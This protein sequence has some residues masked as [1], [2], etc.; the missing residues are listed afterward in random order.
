MK[1]NYPRI[2]K[3]KAPL[4][5]L[6]AVLLLAACGGGGSSGGSSPAGDGGLAGGGGVNQPTSTGRFIDAAVSGIRYA[7]ATQSRFTSALGE[8][9][10]VPGETVT[11]S[12][13]DLTLPP[14]AAKSILTP[15]DLANTDDPS[16][17]RVVNMLV[18]LQS[19]DED[20][21][22]S[23]GIKI[24][25]QAHQVSK[26][27]LDF[28]VAPAAF[29]AHTD[30][31]SLVQSAAGMQRAP[32]TP[33]SAKAHFADTLQGKNGVTVPVA[34]V[35]K[36]TNTVTKIY[37][38][39]A[40][41]IF[42]DQSFH[43]SGE[44]MTYNN[45][46]ITETSPSGK[47]RNYFGLP[48]KYETKTLHELGKWNFSLVVTDSKGLKSRP[49]T[50]EFDVLPVQY[51]EAVAIDETPVEIKTGNY[52]RFVDCAKL[53]Q[54]GEVH[55]ETRLM[56]TNMPADMAQIE[57]ILSM[58]S[59]SSYHE[60]KRFPNYY[61]EWVR[62]FDVM[63]RTSKFVYLTSLEKA[64][65]EINHL[66]STGRSLCEYSDR[67]AVDRGLAKYYVDGKWW[68]TDIKYWW[69]G[70][71]EPYSYDGTGGTYNAITPHIPEKYKT[72]DMAYT[73]LLKPKVSLRAEGWLDEL[74]SYTKAARS[75]IEFLNE[76]RL[77]ELRSVPKPSEYS[78]VLFTDLGVLPEVML[79]MQAYIKEMRVN[80][81]KLTGTAGTYERLQTERTRAYLQHIWSMAEKVLEDGFVHT[82]NSDIGDNSRP[83]PAAMAAMPYSVMADVYAPERIKELHDLGIQ[84]KTA[85]Y[86]KDTYLKK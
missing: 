28:N 22:P 43:P 48:G 27:V 11:F 60:F 10:Y 52:V 68:T 53:M 33:E 30:L 54:E 35:A 72:G 32:V 65:H 70:D 42:L 29:S 83:N 86:W 59:P 51:F 4:T 7:T 82:F 21:N 25:E 74:T 38:G 17:Q 23:N 20:N 14:V 55:S 73:Y 9:V 71:Q 75:T 63:N 81:L 84:T 78:T 80:S 15:L 64:N 18:L 56:P 6:L 3:T 39:R 44:V 67:T 50:L 41:N 49:A 8:F 2:A 66:F 16:D 37:S 69:M 61:T 45:Y 26:R 5:A 24:T 1:T 46:Q 13:G 58:N 31:A 36:M 47:V 40:N 57:R 34:P 12:I 77:F 79:F 19:L 85:D 76:V 62:S